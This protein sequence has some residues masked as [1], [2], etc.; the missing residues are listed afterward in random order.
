MDGKQSVE[1]VRT[2]SRRAFPCADSSRFGRSSDPERNRTGKTPAQNAGNGHAKPGPVRLK[3]CPRER[4]PVSGRAGRWSIRS[5]TPAQGG[6]RR[7]PGSDLLRSCIRLA[8]FRRVSPRHSN[9]T[10]WPWESEA[11]AWAISPWAS[12]ARS[13]RDN[14]ACSDFISVS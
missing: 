11:S 10:L 3:R 2:S 5:E 12:Q 14:R 7:K 4:W 13:L 6:C 8:V 9:G 1:M